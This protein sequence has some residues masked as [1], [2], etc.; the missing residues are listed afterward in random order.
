[1]V[2]GEPK[3]CKSFL[4]LNLVASAAPRLPWFAVPKPGRVLLGA[5]PR[6]AAKSIVSCARLQLPLSDSHWIGCCAGGGAEAPLETLDHEIADHV[7]ADAAGSGI[8][9]HD[10][11][12]AG[13]QR[14]GRC[15]T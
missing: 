12:V 4:A 9:G 11:P 5:T 2:G 1:M 3:C 15:T 7:A 14:E 13:I 8:P 6:S 10:L